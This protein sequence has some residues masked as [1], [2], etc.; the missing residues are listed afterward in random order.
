M[1]KKIALLGLGVIF[2]LGIILKPTTTNASPSRPQNT[3]FDYSSNATVVGTWG[4]NLFQGN[5]DQKK[6]QRILPRGSQWHVLGYTWR[7]DGYYYY[8]GGNQW[9]QAN[10]VKVPVYSGADALL[11]VVSRFGDDTSND[12][13]WTAKDFLNSGFVEVSLEHFNS[14]SYLTTRLYS[15]AQN[16]DVNDVSWSVKPH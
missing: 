14:G 9:I 2:G 4:A 16:G 15:V 12:S 7:G 13:A 3:Y 10:Q 6:F 8:A 5:D 11:N 1:H